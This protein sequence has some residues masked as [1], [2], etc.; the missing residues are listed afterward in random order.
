MFFRVVVVPSHQVSLEGI[1]LLP[2]EV[3]AV[4]HMNLP[5]SLSDFQ[6]FLVLYDITVSF[7]P[8]LRIRET[9]AHPL[10]RQPFCLRSQ[11][12][13]VFSALCEDLELSP[14]FF[15]LNLMYCY[16][17]GCHIYI[18]GAIISQINSNN[19]IIV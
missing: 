6:I 13:A 9:L 10:K 12:I 8:L 5:A 7:P 2:N 18:F 15:I 11:K 19:V 4:Q 3:E 16:F 1:A 17:Y 14:S